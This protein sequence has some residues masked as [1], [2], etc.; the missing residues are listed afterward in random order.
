MGGYVVTEAKD[1]AVSA[2]ARAQAELEE[3]LFQLEKMPLFDAG[4][5]AFAAHALNNYI[6]VTGGTVELM[7]THVADHPDAQLRLWLEGVQHATN[8]MARTVS[9]LMSASA[10]TETQLRFD[11]VD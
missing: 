5:V 2:I 6:T 3:A 7:L 4:S 11:K 8:L 9:Q 1:R 10:P